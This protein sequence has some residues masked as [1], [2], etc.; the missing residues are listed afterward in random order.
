MNENEI[1][2]VSHYYIKDC[3]LE[4]MH[5]LG[6]NFC[7]RLRNRYGECV[8]SFDSEIELDFWKRNLN[9]QILEFESYKSVAKND[10]EDVR[11]ANKQRVKLEFKVSAAIIILCT[12]QMENIAAFELKKI[13]FDMMVHPYDVFFRLNLCSIQIRDMVR[14]N[15]QHFTVLAQ[16]ITETK[17]LI[18]IE[19]RL[20]SFK[21]PN[22]RKKDIE[23]KVAMSDL[24]LN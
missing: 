15:K 23:M 21:S 1:T 2:P 7:I 14:T 10:L 4:D 8:L 16:S 9:E 3:S 22:Y 20:F 13:N 18:D 17:D 11:T 24:E 19:F 5:N 12:E 6:V